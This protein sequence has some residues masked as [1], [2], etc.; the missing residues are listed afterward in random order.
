MTE[1]SLEQYLEIHCRHLQGAIGKVA[2][3]KDL[4]PLFVMDGADGATSV[5]DPKSIQL[6]GGFEKDLTMALFRA[7]LVKVQA[8]RYAVIT[9]CWM[10]TVESEEAERAQREGT[11]GFLKDRRTEGYQITVGD[12]TGSLIASFDTIRDYKGKIRELRRR[13][14]SPAEMFQG[15]FCDLLTTRQ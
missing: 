9:A 11:G 14:T 5:V 7:L 13:P 15:R 6:G 8:V 4:P 10:A 2:A 1:P 3:G 12:H